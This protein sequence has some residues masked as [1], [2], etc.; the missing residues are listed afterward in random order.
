M[1]EK[2]YRDHAMLELMYATGVRVSELIALNVEDVN[3]PAAF[4]RCGDKSGSA[5]FLCTPG[6]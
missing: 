5:S 2:G 3:L 4:L 6:R 1:D